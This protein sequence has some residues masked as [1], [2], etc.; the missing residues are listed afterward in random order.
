MKHRRALGLWLSLLVLLTLSCQT[1]TGLGKPKAARPASTEAPQSG[2]TITPPPGSNANAPVLGTQAETKAALATQP[3]DTLEALAAENYPPDALAQMNKTF[4][5][6]I[7]LPQDQPVLWQY[8]WCATTR[9]IL[10]DNL[11]HLTPK[12]FMNTLPVDISRFY[13]FDSQST[14]PQSNT[15]LQCHSYAVLVSHWPKGETRLQT[16]VTFD[17]Q[18]NDGIGDYQPGSQTFAY[19]V[20]RP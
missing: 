6:T 4:P 1:V 16:I 8:G 15:T 13:T 5:F 2:R 3:Q 19:A 20:T 11:K 18:I 14:D 10:E 17:A 9:A 7:A 12:F